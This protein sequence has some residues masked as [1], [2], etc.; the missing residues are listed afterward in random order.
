MLDP[1]LRKLLLLFCAA[2]YKQGAQIREF[3]TALDLSD[4][5]CDGLISITKLNSGLNE[6]NMAL[7]PAE[8]DTLLTNLHIQMG[9]GFAI[10]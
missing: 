10:E 1:K 5:E 6:F 3:L 4:G 9:G 7:T 8:V 2:A